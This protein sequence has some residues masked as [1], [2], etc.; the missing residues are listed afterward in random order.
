MAGGFGEEGGVNADGQVYIQGG[1]G[2]LARETGDKGRACILAAVLAACILIAPSAARAHDTFL[3]PAKFEIG[4]TETV[5]VALSSASSFPNLEYGPR[6][7]RV[8]T[9]SD[10]VLLSGHATDALRLAYQPRRSGPQVFGLVLGPRDIDLQSADV[11]HYFDE[12]GAPQE[13]RERYQSDVAPHTFQETYTK[14]AKTIVCAAPCRRLD[15][16]A[17]RRLG[18]ALEFTAFVDR[19]G[20]SMRRFRLFANGRP[21][22]DHQVAATTAQGGRR[23]LRT[24]ASGVV[25][26]PDDVHGPTL[27]SAVVL[28]PPARRGERFTSDFA[29][30]T[31]N[32]P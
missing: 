5:S 22:A 20:V 27:L 9:M 4:P 1:R 14:Y 10:G 19:G 16:A 32:A 28:R 2:V 8:A 11:L 7:E 3:M 29:T 31:F 12:I 15:S 30:L 24:N 26:L 6:P 25:D 21:A 17:G 18:H 23:V 13:V